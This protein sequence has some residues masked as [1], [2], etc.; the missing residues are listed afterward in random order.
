MNDVLDVPAPKMAV[1]SRYLQ[2]AAGNLRD[3]TLS[4]FAGVARAGRSRTSMI[5]RHA[6]SPGMTAR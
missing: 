1:T 5:M 6:R 3:G 4:V 2:Y